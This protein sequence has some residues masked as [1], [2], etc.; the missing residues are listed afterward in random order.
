V[1]HGT[2]IVPAGT[3]HL[4]ARWQ[5]ANGAEVDTDMPVVAQPV[6]SFTAPSNLVQVATQ[7]GIA[8]GGVDPGVKGPYSFDVRYRIA[9]PTQAFGKYV[10]PSAWQNTLATSQKVSGNA[11][12][13][14][15]FDVRVHDALKRT[16]P[17]SADSCAIVPL[18][19]R[20]FKLATSGWK[21]GSD[22]AAYLG[23]ITYTSTKGAALKLANV[24]ADG[25]SL[26]VTE[27]PSCGPVSI[28]R[29]SKLLATLPTSAKTTQENVALPL[30]AF[31]QQTTTFTIKAAAAKQ[32]RVDGVALQ[33]AP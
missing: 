22:K 11:G 24:R 1:A 33:Q 8:Y 27:C 3:Y 32:V 29:G 21:R 6:A 25:I 15:C 13:E 28:Y 19:D 16:S 31:P 18:D 4:L 10:L 2:A 30:I 17:W 9:T 20:N 26:V 5:P 14:W 12:Q 23:T 7:F